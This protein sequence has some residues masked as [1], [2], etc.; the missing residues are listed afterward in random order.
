[1]KSL[2]LGLAMAV[3]AA[4]GL[5]AQSA[6]VTSKSKIEVKDGKEVTVTGCVRPS[7]SGTGFFLARVRGEDV[8]SEAYT[9]VGKEDDLGKYVGQLVR[10]KGKATDLGDDA[11]VEVHNKTHVDREGDDKTTESR[12]EIKGDLSMPLLGVQSVK[13]L[14]RACEAR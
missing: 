11:R 14:D 1:M 8:R 5:S 10:I 2:T 12:T 6:T 13:G 3:A 4:V 9:L 7:A